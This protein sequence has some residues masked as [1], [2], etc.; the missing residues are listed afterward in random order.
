[1]IHINDAKLDYKSVLQVRVWQVQSSP[2]KS[3]KY[4]MPLKL[5]SD[6]P[7]YTLSQ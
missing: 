6:L 3:T 7:T 1:M 2:V 4:S 5:N